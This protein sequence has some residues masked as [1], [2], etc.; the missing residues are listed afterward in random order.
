MEKDLDKAREA[1]KFA[2]S[3]AQKYGDEV[4]DALQKS[5]LYGSKESREI[6]RKKAERAMV[7]Y[8]NWRS[9]AEL[10]LKVISD[11]ESRA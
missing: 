10:A 11:I 2:M 5:D 4:L 7:A 8:E 3:E 1:Y 6:F 9:S